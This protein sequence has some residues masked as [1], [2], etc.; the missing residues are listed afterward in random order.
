MFELSFLTILLSFYW[1]IEKKMDREEGERERILS[2]L[3][4]YDSDIMSSDQESADV[5]SVL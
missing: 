5:K 1:Y 3:E 4:S 2:I